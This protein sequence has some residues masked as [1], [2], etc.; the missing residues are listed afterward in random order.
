MPPQTIFEIK[1]WLNVKDENIYNPLNL[2]RNNLSLE[3]I[4]I[5]SEK[6]KINILLKKLRSSNEK[7]LIFVNSRSEAKNI[8]D[9]LNSL[10]VG[11]FSFYYG[12]GD[13]FTNKKL[14]LL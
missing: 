4:E 8:S 5:D 6:N 7:V 13:D 11:K 3:I 10:D 9:T 12:T 1:L 2:E 14:P